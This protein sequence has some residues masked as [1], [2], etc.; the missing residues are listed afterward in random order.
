M[1][2]GKEVD[3]ATRLAMMMQAIDDAEAEFAEMKT[4]HKDRMTRLVNAA[5]ALKRDIL[6]GQL[7]LIPEDAQHDPMPISQVK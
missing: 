6:H 4:E 1:E 7:A 3:R 2:N 5:A